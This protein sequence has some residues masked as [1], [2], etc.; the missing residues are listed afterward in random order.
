MLCEQRLERFGI[1]QRN[2]GSG[3]QDGAIEILQR[4][5]FQ[6]ALN[7]VAGTVLLFLWGN[8]DIVGV[9]GLL[10][11]GADGVDYLFALVAN[12]NSNLFRTNAFGGIERVL[13][14]GATADSVQHFRRIGF[15]SGALT[16]GE[17][18]HSGGRTV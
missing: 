8:D 2:I 1:Q 5:V 9:L 10:C 11:P 7:S 14:H 18:D 17:N 16:R 15:H 6:C 4:R 13:Q 12:D 3:Y